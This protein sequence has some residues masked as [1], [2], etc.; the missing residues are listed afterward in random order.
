MIYCARSM[1]IDELSVLLKNVYGSGF[2]IS[3]YSAANYAMMTNRI[4]ANMKIQD[5]FCQERILA[6]QAYARNAVY[7]KLRVLCILQRV[8]QRH[9]D[10]RSCED[11][12]TDFTYIEN[13]IIMITMNLLHYVEFAVKSES[14]MWNSSMQMLK[15]SPR[16]TSKLRA[17]DYL[18]ISH[19]SKRTKKVHTAVIMYMMELGRM[20]GVCP[21]ALRNAMGNMILR[22]ARYCSLRN[23]C[24]PYK[25]PSTSW[26]SMRASD[27][28]S[29]M[30]A[31]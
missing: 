9:L 29:A 22:Y 14:N 6:I 10:R 27:E 16:S 11:S 8:Y 26:P 20:V 7:I 4:S 2:M 17:K 23:N 15:G 5:Y 18:P 30:I 21:I 13:I 1:S 19:Q 31:I 3:A 12:I 28:N 25:S 24:L